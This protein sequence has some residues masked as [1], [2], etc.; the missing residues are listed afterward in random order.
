MRPLL[1]VAALL[2]AS[3][4]FTENEADK[5]Q[6]GER[7]LEEG[8]SGSVRDGSGG[9][10]VDGSGSASDRENAMGQVNAE[11]RKKGLK[12]KEVPK[13]GGATADKAINA[14]KYAVGFGVAG[15]VA[16][17][18]IG[19]PG[20]AI[21]GAALGAGVGFVVGFM[22]GGKPEGGLDSKISADARQ[23]RIDAAM[24]GE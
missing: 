20:G 22:L 23:S 13:T 15:F 7:F 2:C 10:G 1:I 19:G 16:G 3:P 18:L 14:G 4:A 6:S 5:A 17:G 11:G 24:R 12:T 9:A 8:G 21:A